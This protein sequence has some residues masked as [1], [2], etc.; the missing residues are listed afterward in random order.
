MIFNLCEFHVNHILA[1]RG[2]HHRTGQHPRHDCRCA[3]RLV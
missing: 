1:L 2:Q 3:H